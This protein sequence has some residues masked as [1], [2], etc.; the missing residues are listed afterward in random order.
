MNKS[1]IT[2]KLTVKTVLK[3]ILQILLLIIVLYILAVFLEI[4]TRPI[5]DSF[6]KNK[7][8]ELNSQM[9]ILYDDIST[10][11]N[12]AEDW[13]YEASCIEQLNGPWPTG[14]YICSNIISTRKTVSSVQ[15]VNDLQAKYYPIVDNN[16]IFTPISELDPEY[17]SDFGKNFVV[18]S[19]EKNYTEKTSKVTC[20]YLLS[21]YQN[22]DSLYENND[23]YSSAIVGNTGVA[24]IK[25]E[26]TSIARG[27]WYDKKY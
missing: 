25:V 3:R 8:V 15:E 4:A 6:D 18:S 23:L 24:S 9:Q 21:L 20:N 2:K 27:Q 1:I 14:R 7:Y 17:P 26:C 19:V 10:A 16:N 22:P 13:Q 5:R 11:S 12:G